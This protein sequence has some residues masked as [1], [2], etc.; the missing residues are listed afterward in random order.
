[1]HKVL[2]LKLSVAEFVKLILLLIGMKEVTDITY[3]D[4]QNLNGEYYYSMA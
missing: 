4:G 1:L 2:F 3:I